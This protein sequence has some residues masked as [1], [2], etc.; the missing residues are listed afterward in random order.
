MTTE[1]VGAPVVVLGLACLVVMTYLLVDWIIG[2]AGI[3][4]LAITIGPVGVVFL[5]SPW[6][7][8]C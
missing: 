3:P 4:R 2:R 8:H 6:F 7:W 1:K 5:R